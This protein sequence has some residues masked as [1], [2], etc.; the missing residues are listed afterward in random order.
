V[1]GAIYCETRPDRRLRLSASGANSAAEGLRQWNSN[2]RELSDRRCEPGGQHKSGGYGGVAARRGDGDSEVRDRRQPRVLQ[3][4]GRGLYIRAGSAEITGCEILSG[5]R[6]RIKGG[7]IAI[8]GPYSKVG[9]TMCYHIE[10]AQ[11]GRDLD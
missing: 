4:P 7:G 6:I 2:D 1:G 3:R 11:I 10:L 5:T 9:G 8:G